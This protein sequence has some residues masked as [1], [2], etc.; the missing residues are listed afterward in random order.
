MIGCKYECVIFNFKRPVLY[1]SNSQ[2]IRQWVKND[3]VT[4]MRWR[5]NVSTEHIA[6]EQG[7]RALQSIV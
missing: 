5:N 1:V 3:F 6:D 4:I 2:L 7:D